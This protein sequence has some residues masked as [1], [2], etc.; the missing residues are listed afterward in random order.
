M[1]GKLAIICLLLFI[2]C[3]ISTVCAEDTNDTQ[4]MQESNI[5]D[6]LEIN[7]DSILED[8][9]GDLAK[10]INSAPAGSTV[11]LNK[12]YAPADRV[13]IDKSLSIDGAGNTIDCSKAQLRS[14]SGDITLKN[15]KFINGNSFNGGAIHIIGSA[16]FTIINCTF[17]NNQASSFGGAIYN[18]VVDTLTVRDCKFTGNKATTSG[19]AIFSKGNVV[20]EK[21]IFENNQAKV[22]GGA[23]HCEKSVEI[24][25]STFNSNK[26]D[27]DLLTAHGGAINAKKGHNH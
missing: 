17:T 6:C 14:S 11:K 26:V 3:S 9:G 15:L 21:S 10:V 22:D 25:D 4:I 23:I 16:R 12:S 19:G 20:V 1:K 13:N 24:S 7:Q 5:D 8:D 18:N 27:G 2:L